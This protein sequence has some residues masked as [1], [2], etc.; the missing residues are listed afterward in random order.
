MNMVEF[1]IL[2]MTLIFLSVSGCTTP[3][4]YN[5]QYED[6]IAVSTERKGSEWDQNLSVETKIWNGSSEQICV[7]KEIVDNPN[8]YAVSFSLKRKNGKLVQISESGFIPPPVSGRY[9]IYPN[10]SLIFTHSLSGYFMISNKQFKNEGYKKIR[11]MV[12]LFQCDN[13]SSINAT[14]TWQLLD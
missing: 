2:V 4:V 7:E 8:S 14:S 3:T 6:L 5:Q 13:G 9:V 11:T 10:K 1:K 12:P